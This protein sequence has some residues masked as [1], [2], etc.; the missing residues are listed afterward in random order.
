MKEALTKV[1]VFRANSHDG[2]KGEALAGKYEVHGLPHFV[3][4]DATGQTIDRWV[5]FRDADNWLR[6]FVQATSDLTTAEAKEQRFK[7]APKEALAA[8]LGRIDGS[9]G[10]LKDSVGFYR[11]A[12]RLVVSGPKAEYASAIFLTFSSCIVR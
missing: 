7:T 4:M 5:G 12:Q 6:T 1:L 3:L 11:E 8:A 9:R 2:E 10:Q